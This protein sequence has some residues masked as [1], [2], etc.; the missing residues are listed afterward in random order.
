MNQFYDLR[1]DK[2]ER[3]NNEDYGK[4]L[5]MSFEMETLNC[6]VTYTPEWF[7]MEDKTEVE[8]VKV[9]ITKVDERKDKSGNL[10]AFCKGDVGGGVEIDLIVFS[11]IYLNN[12]P[13]IKYDETVYLSG[14]K[15]SDSKM[16]V[17]KVSLS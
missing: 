5:I 9:R 6:P 15:E 16:I 14:K 1:K 3:L 11:S 12:L 10:M 8:N 2:D 13:Y 17:R 7:S 4:E